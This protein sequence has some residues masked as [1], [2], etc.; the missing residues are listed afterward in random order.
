MRTFKI[1]CTLHT[2]YNIH[3]VYVEVKMYVT[4][5]YMYGVWRQRMVDQK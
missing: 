1:I 3:E 2:L 4:E 5:K